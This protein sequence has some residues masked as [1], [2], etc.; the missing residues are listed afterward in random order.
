MA[1]SSIL[2]I[3]QI[4]GEIISLIEETKDYCFL[5][6]PYF[7]PWPVLSRSLEKAALSEK[8]VIFIFRDTD[9]NDQI[10]KEI[11]NY[12]FDI[13]FVDRL[14]TKLYLNEKSAIISSMNL[15]DSSKEYNYEL[16]YKFTN[17][18]EVKKFKEEVIEKDIL[19]LAPKYSINGRYFEHLRKLKEEKLEKER[20]IE[21]RKNNAISKKNELK[22]QKVNTIPTGVCI[23]CGTA[24]SYNTNAPFCYNCYETWSSF[25]NAEY[26]EKYCHSC[27]SNYPTSMRK[28]VCHRCFNK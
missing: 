5:V 14:H 6:T 1:T 9:N 17:S 11:C 22:I 24:I 2:T 28:P 26:E 21:E 15:Y 19:G 25:G 7:K 20:K 12:G 23:R 27:G 18:Y 4:P 13:H 3:H 16:G 10:I 8:K